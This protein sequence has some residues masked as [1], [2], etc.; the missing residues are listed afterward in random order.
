MK[1]IINNI[2]YRRILQLA[3]LAGSVFLAYNGKDGWGWLMFF[4]LITL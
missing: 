4:L 1:Q 2:Q 3:L